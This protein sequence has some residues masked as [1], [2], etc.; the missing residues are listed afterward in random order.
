MSLVFSM[1]TGPS[2]SWLLVGLAILAIALGIF[3]GCRPYPSA[4]VARLVRWYLA[5]AAVPCLVLVLGG[6]PNFGAVVVGIFVTLPWSLFLP[7]LLIDALGNRT[8]GGLFFICAELNAAA[9]YTV[10]ALSSRRGSR[11]P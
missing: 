5:A 11:L 1:A 10:G 4:V 3:Y 7:D 8:L 6:E 9:L 2:W